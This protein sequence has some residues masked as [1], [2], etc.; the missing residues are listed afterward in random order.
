[1][2][3]LK[4]SN[5]SLKKKNENHALHTIAVKTLGIGKL[6][7]GQIVIKRRIYLLKTKQSI[8]L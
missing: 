8:T 2:I 1:M 6:E 3:S 5:K 4:N 7:F